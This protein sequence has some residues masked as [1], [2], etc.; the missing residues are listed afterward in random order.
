MIKNNVKCSKMA[1]QLLALLVHG[2]IV[3]NYCKKY[4]NNISLQCIKEPI[5]ISDSLK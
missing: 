4:V 2:K 3:N 5:W 1:F